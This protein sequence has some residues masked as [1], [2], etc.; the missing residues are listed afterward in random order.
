M[1]TSFNVVDSIPATTNSHL[2]K[3]ILREQLNFEGF[4]ISDY[5]S[6]EETILHKTSKNSKDVAKKSINAGL[7]H[8]MVSRTY[9]DYLEELVNENE[10]K[11]E[12]IDVAVERMLYFKYKIG[13]FDN[14]YKNF[15]SDFSSYKPT[16]KSR[17]LSRE[18]ARESIVLLKNN[19]AL[20]LNKKE[21]IAL[22][23]PFSD[24]KKVIG[25]W[26]CMIKEDE[27]ISVLE[28][29]KRVAPNATVY[30][31]QGCDIDSN[32]KSKFKRAIEL[33]KK[34]NVII[35]AV[36][37][38]SLMSGEGASR[39]YID[40]PGVQKD[41][42]EEMLKLNK[43]TILLLFNGRPLDLTWYNDKVDAIVETW[44]LATESGN[45]IS[46]II[47]GDYNP[48]AK[49]TMSFPYGTGQIPVYYNSLTT[50]RPKMDT[51]NRFWSH[52]IDIPNEALYPFGYGLS[53]TKYEYSNLKVDK[54]LLSGED[55]ILEVAIDV[56]NAG[57]M[58][59]YEIVQ[60][61]IEATYFSVARPK[62]ELKG[63][64]K[65]FI[66]SGEKTTI[67]LKLKASDLAYYKNSKDCVVG[68]G[69]YL[70]KVGSSSVNL[71]ETKISYIP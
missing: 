66:K 6:S 8:E 4:V 42:V 51:G 68:E 21:K 34:S 41:L 12:Q 69:D 24:S 67:I 28:G 33:A 63:Y 71:L 47:F 26:G 62:N 45:A 53:Y 70:I 44:F 49:L 23:G 43:K 50:G 11:I 3:H 2:L 52:Y 16:E 38:D 9:L 15:Y 46:D 36:G 59:G 60:L 19:N 37:E 22:I 20:P 10:V 27:C 31:E 7:D 54:T 35:L 1:M 48:N 40:L 29:I 18:M 30:V 14:P 55:D 17:Q 58:D 56:L 61:Y 57:D 13:L 65:E 5:T 32:D 39:A 25:A 64:K